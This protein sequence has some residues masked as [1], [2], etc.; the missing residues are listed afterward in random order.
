MPAL[1][2]ALASARAA[3]CLDGLAAARIGRRV[4]AVVAL[5]AVALTGCGSP[6]RDGEG[7]AP[8]RQAEI[9]LVGGMEPPPDDARWQPQSL[10]DDWS[11]SRPTSSG[12]AWYRIELDR[13]VDPAQALAVYI[14]RLNMTGGAFMN[15]VALG[16][17]GRLDEPMTR[18]WYRPQ[19][20]RVPPEVLRPDR[21]VLHVRI[22]T[23]P[24][25]Q[26]GLS[27][28]YFGAAA[29]L[30]ARWESHVFRQVTAM[31]I[32][33]GITAALSLLV[34]VAWAVLR[35]H[36][37][38]GWF[39]LATAFWTLHSLLVLAVE[40]P[41]PTLVWEVAV[42][43]SMVWVIVA[44]MMFALRFAGLERKWLERGA[45]G[46]AG[47]A[48]LLL[49]LAG[50]EQIFGIANACLL[51]LICIGVYEFKVLLDVAR[52]TRSVESV[53][54]ILAG[55]WVL[56]LGAHDWLN[57]QGV[58]TYAEPFDLHYGLPVL[59]IAVF[60]N[61]LGQVAAARRASEALNRELE[62]RVQ[63]KAEELERSAERLRA[64]HAAEALAAERE[65]IMRDMHDGVGSQ[66]IA[67]RQLAARGTLA[68]GE[69]T[70]LLDECIDDLRL[71]IDSLEPVDGDL[72][73]VLGNLRYRLGDRLERQGIAL[74][75]QVSELPRFPGLTPR[76]T[77]QILRI[78][79]EA[80]ANVVKHASARRVALSAALAPDGRSVR[81]SI[82]DDGRGMDDTARARGR[83]LRNMAERARALGASLEVEG[84]PGHCG[85][86]LV[87]PIEVP[88]DRN[89]AVNPD[90][91]SESI[92]PE[93]PALRRVR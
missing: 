45:L 69:L 30:V 10:P 54:L 61:L 12:D 67:T 79:Q 24:D 57:R 4:A 36:R 71:M 89:E 35:W 5:L 62:E 8:I 65:R 86:T 72:L 41:L 20:Y 32:T 33:T 73:T 27:E 40:I 25:N 82:R 2:A 37:A 70:T 53:L 75:W 55:L 23:Y 11:R 76:D 6:N 47:L 38:Y 7:P 49:W 88:A 84:S 34:L 15:G 93:P 1:V 64:A 31:Q 81:I 63:Q 59:F 22:R 46:F 19:L 56:A 17:L 44:M 90:R 29:P 58:W 13:P 26:G 74:E 52:R 50:V 87:L 39:G 16:D 92:A 18:R 68:P 80:F 91:M 83:G 77:L 28:V 21:N 3:A 60:W 51:I 14:P 42:I 48:P 9:L 78:V 85:V 43:G 66:L